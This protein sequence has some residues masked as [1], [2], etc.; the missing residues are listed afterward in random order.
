MNTARWILAAALA[1]AMGAAI[2]AEAPKPGLPNPEYCS[3]RD[4]DPEKCVIQDGPP[5][6]PIV[7]TKPAPPKEPPVPETPAGKLR[8]KP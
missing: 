1:G 3:R 8:A 7:R 2:A 4:A 5:Q 6:Q